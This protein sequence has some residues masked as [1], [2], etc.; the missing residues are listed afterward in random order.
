MRIYNFRRFAGGIIALLLAVGCG[1]ALAIQGFQTRLLVSLILLLALGGADIAWALNREARLPRGDER[2]RAVSQKSAWR[3]FLIL[4]NGCFF[5]AITLLLAYA[6]SKSTM[7]LTA[8]VTLCAVV[9]AAFVILL[10]ANVYYE[11]KL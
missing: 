9:V 10:G 2:D 11:K 4:T 5:A 8:A 3:A 6:V 7:L 1:A